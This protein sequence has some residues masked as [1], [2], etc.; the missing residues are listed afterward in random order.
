MTLQRR[1]TL[2]MVTSTALMLVAFPATASAAD[3]NR[4]GLPDRWER[5]HGLSLKVKQAWR[6]QDGDGLRNLYEY[7][8]GTSPRDAD[9]DNDGIRDYAEDRDRDTLRNGHEQRSRTQPNDADSD[10]DGIRDDNDNQDR[11]GLENEEE[12]IAGT[13]PR[14]ADSDND[15]VRDSDEDNDGD[16]VSNEDEC[17]VGD[18]PNDA[19]SDDDGILDGSEV[20]G[21]ILS[22]DGT[23]L[24]VTRPNGSTLSAP[25]ALNVE[26]EID[27]CDTPNIEGTDATV[28]ALAP[29]TVLKRIKLNGSGAITDIKIA[30]GSD[31]GE[32][33]DD[34]DDED[35]DESNDD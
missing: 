30:S 4:D 3:R 17:S 14:D 19:D 13:H 25:L 23:M 34:E 11:D 24:V 7:R 2:L 28:A 35:E 33:E 22:F 6:D 21:T 15:G 20:R 31:L 26:I 29:G 1:H 18:N 5:R 16:G 9:S 10:N 8:A 12:I 32:N 27:D